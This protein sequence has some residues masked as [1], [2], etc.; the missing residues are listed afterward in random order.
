MHPRAGE[1]KR[2][3]VNSRGRAEGSHETVTGV[4]D[5]GR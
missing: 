5:Q 2:T 3:R 4:S 1:R